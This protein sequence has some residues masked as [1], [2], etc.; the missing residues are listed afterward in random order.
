MWGSVDTLDYVWRSR[1]GFPILHLMLANA[2]AFRTTWQLPCGWSWRRRT[3]DPVVLAAIAPPP[4]P[5]FL[6]N[7]RRRRA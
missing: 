6:H 5:T 7:L 4:G 1:A 2:Y 3:N